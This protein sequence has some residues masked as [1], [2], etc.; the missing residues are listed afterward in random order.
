[1]ADREERLTG[2]LRAKCVMFEC[3]G[4][5]RYGLGSKGE[6]GHEV[7]SSRSTGQDDLVFGR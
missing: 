1:M 3:G 5:S 4:L 6:G 7:N 2:G